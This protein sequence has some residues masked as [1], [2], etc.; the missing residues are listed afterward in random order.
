MTVNFFQYSFHG[1]C[2]VINSSGHYKRL[3]EKSFTVTGH[4]CYSYWPPGQ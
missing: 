2:I 1:H 3:H 4:R